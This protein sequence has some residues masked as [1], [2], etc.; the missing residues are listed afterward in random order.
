MTKDEM[1]HII[2]CTLPSDCH[3]QDDWNVAHANV[4]PKSLLIGFTSLTNRIMKF[5]FPGHALG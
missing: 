5:L 1:L 2:K 3:V 4:P